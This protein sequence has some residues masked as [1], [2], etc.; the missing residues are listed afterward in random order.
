MSLRDE[1]TGL[2]LHGEQVLTVLNHAEKSL[3]TT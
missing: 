3:A 2:A 1:W